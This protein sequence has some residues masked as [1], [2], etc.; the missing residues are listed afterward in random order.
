MKWT[1]VFLVFLDGAVSHNTKSIYI[2]YTVDEAA[3]AITA[4]SR[5]SENVGSLTFGSHTVLED[6]AKIA[7]P[8]QSI[9]EP[10]VEK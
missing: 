8:T 4:F 1:A 6:T 2:R 3:H 5:L 7:D 9:C 10:L